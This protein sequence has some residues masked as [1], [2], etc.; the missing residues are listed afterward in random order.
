MPSPV[1]RKLVPVQM[2]VSK[3]TSTPLW[4]AC[5]VRP[6]SV[7]RSASPLWPTI[8]KRPWPAATP[9]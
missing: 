4:A 6:S 8:T 5:Q 3:L 9:V 1:A 2:M 7:E